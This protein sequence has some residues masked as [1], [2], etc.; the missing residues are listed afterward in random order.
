[1]IPLLMLCT[2][3]P[4]GLKTKAICAPIEPA[5]I[6]KSYSGHQTFARREQRAASAFLPLLNT[7]NSSPI[8]SASDFGFNSA[9]R[10]LSISASF[11]SSAMYSL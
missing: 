4:S 8:F 5:C 1:M 11:A 2:A 7:L 10:L 6:T 9:A 3:P